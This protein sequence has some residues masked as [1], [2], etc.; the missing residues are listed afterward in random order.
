VL[1]QLR[2]SHQSWGS[3][4]AQSGAPVALAGASPAALPRP[5]SFLCRL[6]ELSDYTQ[7]MIMFIYEI[8]PH[9]ST[10]FK[11]IRGNSVFQESEK[12]AAQKDSESVT[13]MFF[14]L[15]PPK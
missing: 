1:L 6:L 10:Y 2:A 3:S 9:K 11:T 15:L 7:K 4:A 14:D 12:F 8:M 5:T 13:S